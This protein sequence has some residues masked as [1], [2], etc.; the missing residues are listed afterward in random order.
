MYRLGLGILEVGCAGRIQV[1]RV[2][3]SPRCRQAMLIA[4]PWTLLAVSLTF[5]IAIYAVEALCWSF[6]KFT[7]AILDR[8]LKVS[9]PSLLRP[10]EGA[11]RIA[12]TRSHCNPSFSKQRC[13]RQVVGIL[14][15]LVALCAAL[16][17]PDPWQN[18]SRSYFVTTMR[19]RMQGFT[20][21]NQS[22][23]AELQVALLVERPSSCCWASGPRR[24]PEAE[25]D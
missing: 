13:G 4:V 14:Q 11:T 10:L 23:S 16:Y 5:F 18:G 9:L 1:L 2:V 6:S 22:Q 15:Y 20:A 17:L 12:T 8:S 19:F 24:P 25:L 3:T 7:V 21:Y